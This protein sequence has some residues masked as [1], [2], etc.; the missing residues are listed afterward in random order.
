[1]YVRYVASN[2]RN[3]YYRVGHTDESTPITVVHTEFDTFVC[4]TCR[5][6]TCPHSK[7]TEDSDAA[8]ERPR[9]PAE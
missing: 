9:Q 8:R 3:D 1:V 7:A 5:S 2:K 4:L 6:H